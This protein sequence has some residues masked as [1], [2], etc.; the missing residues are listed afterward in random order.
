M[1]NSMFW[2]WFILRST[3]VSA[4][5]ALP[6]NNAP[7]HFGK[8]FSLYVSFSSY[9][10]FLQIPHNC[11]SIIAHANP[12]QQYKLDQHYIY[13]VL[14]VNVM[15]C[16]CLECGNTFKADVPKDGELVTC[17]ICEAVY[18]IVVE[19]GR[20]ELKEYIYE[21]EDFGEL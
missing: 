20:V 19:D 11:L 10:T 6:Y 21:S 17:P 8:A 14:A 12:K 9:V 5:C 13:A 18:R 7:V 15:I 2:K 3:V 1:S 4:S 16:K